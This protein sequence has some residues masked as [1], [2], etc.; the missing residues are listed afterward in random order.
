MCHHNTFLLYCSI[1]NKSLAKWNKVTHASI[2]ISFITMILMA[3]AGYATFT[4]HVQGDLNFRALLVSKPC[5]ALWSRLT[6]FHRSQLFSLTLCS[7]DEGFALESQKNVPFMYFLW[8]GIC[9]TTIVGPMIWWTSRG[10]S[11]PSPFYWLTP[12]NAS[13][14]EKWCRMSWATSK[15]IWANFGTQ[16]SQLPSLWRPTSYRWSR[17]ASPPS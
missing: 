7:H 6:F 12:S 8:K 4:G 16:A 11:F 13:F 5:S 10:F 2:M 17:T 15:K 1:D 3:F 9:W 14:V